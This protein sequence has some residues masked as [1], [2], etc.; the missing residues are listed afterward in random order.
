MGRVNHRSRHRPI[1]G[2]LI[3]AGL[4]AMLVGGY[5]YIVFA[6]PGRSSRTATLVEPPQIPGPSTSA[7]PAGAAD[8]AAS[9]PIRV[10]ISAIGVNSALQPLG[11]LKDGSLQP[12]ADSA[13]A[14]WYSK[15]IIPGNVGPAVI[16]GYVDSMAG[17]AV[18]SRLR[19]LRLGD[20]ITVQRQDGD[21]LHFE[22]DDIRAYAQLP[23]PSSAVYGPSSVP[24]LRLVT[25]SDALDSAGRSYLQ[26]LVISAHLN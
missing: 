2:T 4:I 22:V 25:C 17:P 10:A 7:A 15:G 26:N 23:L 9:K 1:A 21:V 14:G 5:G 20:T 16:A 19:D 13:E 24:T 6:E 18:F 3:S 11:L 8:I 12:P